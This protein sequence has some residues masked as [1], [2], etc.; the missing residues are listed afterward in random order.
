MQSHSLRWYRYSEVGTAVRDDQLA[1]VRSLL[2][3]TSNEGAM[4]SL[5]RYRYSAVGTAVRD[6]Q[7]ANVRSLL[8]DTS[9]EGAIALP[10]FPRKYQQGV[11]VNF[12]FCT[13]LLVGYNI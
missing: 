9:N 13:S 11:L 10:F 3:A 2:E 5:R 12:F 8:E 7:L 4:H 1:N 6:D